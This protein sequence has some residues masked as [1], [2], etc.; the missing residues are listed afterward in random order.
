MRSK[1]R[2]ALSIL[3]EYIL[4]QQTKAKKLKDIVRIP[5]D[6]NSQLSSAHSTSKFVPRFPQS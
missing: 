4:R 6:K 2:L 1:V 5:K 3:L